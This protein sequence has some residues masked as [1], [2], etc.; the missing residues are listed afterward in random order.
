M[1]NNE[2]SRPSNIETINFQVIFEA[3]PGSFIVVQPD[4]PDFTVLAVS[5]ELLQLTAAKREEVVG[6]SIFVAYP[7]NPQATPA[8]GPSNLRISLENA[9]KYK[10]QDQMPVIRYDVKNAEG[11]FE[12]R[13]WRANSKPVLSKEG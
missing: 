12:E 11:I 6:K 3:I 5:E 10:K 13:Y 8:T 9:L 2:L 7:E 1:K 4:E